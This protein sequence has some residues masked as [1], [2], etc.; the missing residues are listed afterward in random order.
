MQTKQIIQSSANVIRITSIVKGN[1]YKRFDDNYTWLGVVR[2]VYND[3]DKAIVEATEY[4][5]GWSGIETQDK[6]IKGEQDYVIFPATLE[7]FKLEFNTAI[8]KLEGKI[9]DAKET[10]AKSEEQIEFT[11][12]LVSG[13]LQKELSTPTFK[14]ISQADYNAKLAEIAG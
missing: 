9:K 2:G 10:I 13:E 5:N 3:G 7:D 12:K 11:Q 14:E 8:T 1:I 4:R 6:I